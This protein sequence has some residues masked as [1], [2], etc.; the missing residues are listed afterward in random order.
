M[1]LLLL[2]FSACQ[3]AEKDAAPENQLGGLNYDFDISSTAKEGFDKGL[4]LLHSFEYEDAQEAFQEA[5]KM[6]STEVMAYWGEAMTHYKA[7]WGLQDVE[8]GRAVIARLGATPE[9]RL[10]TIDNELEKDFWQALELL[11]GEGTLKERNQ[12]Y[13]DHMAGLYQ[14]YPSNQ[15]V[16]AFYALGLMWSVEG[17][18]DPE[19]FDLSARVA[20]GILTENPNHPGALHYMIHANDD[21]DYAKLSLLAANKY[22]KVAPGA[23]HALHMPSHIYLALGM[24]NDVVAS[25]ERSYAA[26]LDRMERKGLDDKARGYHSYAW[27]H[28]GYLQQGRFAK[29]AELLQDMQTYTA[30]TGDENGPRRY[31]IDMQNAQRIESGK[32]ELDFEPV[33]IKYT[34]LGLNSQSSYHFLNALSA[35]D[36]GNK[37]RIQIE[38][39][40]LKMR[41][42]FAEYIVTNDKAPICSAGPTRYA[43]NQNDLRQSKVV[44]HQMEALLAQLNGDD[45]KTEASMQSA[46]QLE[47]ECD[48][49]YGPPQI[50]YPS[51]EQYGDWLLAKKRYPEAIEQFDKSLKIGENRAKALKGKMAALNAL[52]Q[53]AEAA[54]IQTTLDGF[55]KGEAQ[56][57]L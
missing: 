25:N 20:E 1:S 23:T 32:W 29:A 39:D 11:Y 10:Q 21:P 46:T 48:Y 9:A 51:Y 45:A 31:L 5:V 47:D 2:I 13:A 56:E 38:I 57:V 15:E 6:D 44:V 17:S 41:A 7:L 37:A 40:T 18:R 36:Q 26:S 22:D 52:G 53:K 4:L 42:K 24:W 43:P 16:A 30:N 50:Q 14:K 54:A 28:Y 35:F 12:A 34:G 49:S 27:L 55:W 8:G 33:D 19:V 3:T